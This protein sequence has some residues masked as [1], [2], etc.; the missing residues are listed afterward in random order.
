[1]LLLGANPKSTPVIW[2]ADPGAELIVILRVA[3]V[4]VISK[5]YVAAGQ[6]GSGPQFVRER[7]PMVSALAGVAKARARARSPKVVRSFDT[8]DPPQFIT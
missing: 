8:K 3:D 1:M 4:A 7:L 2:F 5:L 6:P